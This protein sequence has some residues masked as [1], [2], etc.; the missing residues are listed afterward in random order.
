[1]EKV[2]NIEQNLEEKFPNIDK[3]IEEKDSNFGFKPKVKFPENI[4]NP[5]NQVSLPKDLITQNF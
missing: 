4:L 3:I 5:L 2:P 1:M